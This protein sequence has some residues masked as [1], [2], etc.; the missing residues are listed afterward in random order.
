MTMD[1]GLPCDCAPDLAAAARRAVAAAGRAG[2]AMVIGLCLYETAAIASRRLPTVSALC[3]R[4][5]WVEAALLAVLIA[6]L[7]HNLAPEA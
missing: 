2:E 6:H 3:R 7:H 4:R 5:R 1:D